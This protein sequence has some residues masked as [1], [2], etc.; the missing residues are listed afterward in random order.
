MT[1]SE[2]RA[3]IRILED[4]NGKKPYTDYELLKKDLLI[5]FGIRITLSE[6]RELLDELLDIPSLEEEVE[7]LQ[8]MYK[9][10]SG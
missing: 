5:E 6:I 4:L 1:R 3:Y 10:I 8:I 9:N 7:D 2:F